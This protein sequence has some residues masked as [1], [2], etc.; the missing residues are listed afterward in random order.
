MKLNRS[1]V[2]ESQSELR[3]NGCRQLRQLADPFKVKWCPFASGGRAIEN[4]C[5]QGLQGKYIEKKEDDTVERTLEAC[6][7]EGSGNLGGSRLTSGISGIRSACVWAG[8]RTRRL[9][10]GKWC[11][12][13]PGNQAAL[14][15]TKAELAGLTAR[16]D[17]PSR[18]VPR[19]HAS[20]VRS[21]SRCCAYRRM[22]RS[23][24]YG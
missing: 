17:L 15:K 4:A 18:Q 20:K 9:A 21:R 7:S 16:I 8:Q 14:T 23:R 1:R 2:S 12:A 6:T 3:R 5:F 13:E 11:R 22:L 19:G 24:S 10:A